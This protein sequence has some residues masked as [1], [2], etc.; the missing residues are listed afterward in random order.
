M[1]PKVITTK[2]G[3]FIKNRFPPAR[4]LSDEDRLLGNGILDSLAILDVVAFIE[5][6]FSIMISDDELLPE[7]F[8]SISSMAAF[9]QSKLE[10]TASAQ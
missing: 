5:K 8:N 4:K 6:E 1:Q 10:V 7:N 3:E 9:V 2:I